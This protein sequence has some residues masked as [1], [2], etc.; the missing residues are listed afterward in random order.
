ML[1]PPPGL[2]CALQPVEREVI[3]KKKYT[4]PQ[5][6]KIEGVESPRKLIMVRHSCEHS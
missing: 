2:S 3:K 1:G 6:V 5:K 4:S